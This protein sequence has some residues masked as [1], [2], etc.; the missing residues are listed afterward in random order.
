MHTGHI[1]FGQC[2]EA[3]ENCGQSFDG[4]LYSC[5]SNR[6]MS[7]ITKRNRE[8]RKADRMCVSLDAATSDDEGHSLLDFMPSSFD[9]FE[10]ATRAQVGEYQDDRVRIYVSRLSARQANILSLLA[11]GYRPNEVRKVM[12]ISKGE[13]VGDMEAMRSYENVKILF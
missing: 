1:L 11:D 8:K 5:L 3:T 6:I 7:E 2:K 4:F 9:T 13:Y 10:E 12:G